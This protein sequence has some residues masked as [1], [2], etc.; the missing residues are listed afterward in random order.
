LQAKI[1]IFAPLIKIQILVS[2]ITLQRTT[3]ELVSL[4]AMIFVLEPNDDVL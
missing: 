1:T 4:L 2:L 3:F